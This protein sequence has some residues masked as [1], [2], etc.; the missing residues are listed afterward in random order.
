MFMILYI[1][2][3]KEIEMNKYFKLL[4]TSICIVVLSGCTQEQGK[5]LKR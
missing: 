1:Q 4:L 2:I 5:N 3:N